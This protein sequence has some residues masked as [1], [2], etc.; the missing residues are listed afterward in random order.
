[1]FDENKMFIGYEGIIFGILR[2]YDLNLLSLDDEFF[3]ANEEFMSDD[4]DA[5]TK[6]AKIAAS[7]D[8]SREPIGRLHP[9]NDLTLLNYPEKPLFVPVT[10]VA[11]LYPSRTPFRTV[12]L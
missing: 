2:P 7:T 11:L 5:N 10:Q 9:L 6:K 4:E 12:A 3:D 8:A 1:M